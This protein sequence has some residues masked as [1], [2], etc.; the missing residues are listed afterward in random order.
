[1]NAR[2]IERNPRNTRPK[3]QKNQSYKN[4]KKQTTKTPVSSY[5]KMTNLSVFFLHP[6]H[7]LARQQIQQAKTQENHL[8]ASQIDSFH[9]GTRA[10]EPGA[11]KSTVFSAGMSLGRASLGNPNPQFSMQ[12]GPKPVQPGA[13]KSAVFSAGAS[14]A[15]P[16]RQ[17][18]VRERR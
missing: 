9:S 4:P 2:V 5:T 18:S 17:F 8:F 3:N 13:P 10:S 7:P 1:M 15:H 12:N 6:R 14:L 11:P 16:N